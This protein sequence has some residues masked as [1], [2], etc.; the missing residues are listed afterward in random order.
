MHGEHGEQPL[1]SQSK[2]CTDRSHGRRCHL[3][4]PL[5]FSSA[6]L[7]TECQA[8][9]H[10]FQIELPPPARLC[11][12]EQTNTPS[13]SKNDSHLRAVR[14]LQTLSPGQGGSRRGLKTRAPPWIPTLYAR[15]CCSFSHVQLFVTLRTA[16]CHAPLSMGFSRQEYRSRLSHPPPGDRL[17][18]GIEPRSPVTPALQVGS[19]PLSHRGS[20]DSHLTSH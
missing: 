13:M 3:C 6:Q 8:N 4:G 9:L 2:G 17:H 10:K 11:D 1:M 7:P 15:A 12:P 16:A 14:H 18:R 5:P 20:P 19:L